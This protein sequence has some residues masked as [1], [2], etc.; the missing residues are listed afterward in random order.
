[1]LKVQVIGLPGAGKTS[2]IKRFFK[3]N[4]QITASYL[5]I[6]NFHGTNRNTKF[7]KTFFTTPTPCIAESACGIYSLASIVI[8]LDPP[9]STV[10]ERCLLRDK[11]VDPDYL[12]LLA[13][14][15]IPAHYIL[16]KPDDLVRVLKD[17]FTNVGINKHADHTGEKRRR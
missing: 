4:P 9:I 8:K 1:M 11:H 15:Q 6:R 3:E 10:Y 12:S 17:L 7:Q 14:E 5:D 16:E 2:A 13:S